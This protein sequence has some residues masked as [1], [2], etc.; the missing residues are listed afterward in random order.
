M[1]HKKAPGRPL[2]APV[3]PF[4]SVPLSYPCLPPTE[5]PTRDP[6]RPPVN[7]PVAPF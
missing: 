6:V 1:T 7:A 2:Q 5:R 3:W 4:P